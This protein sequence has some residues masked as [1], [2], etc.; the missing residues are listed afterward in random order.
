MLSKYSE[1]VLLASKMMKQIFVVQD[2]ETCLKRP[3][4]LEGIRY[5]DQ[6][7]KRGHLYLT[8]KQLRQKVIKAYPEAER[9]APELRQVL[10]PNGQIGDY[11]DPNSHYRKPKK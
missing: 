10:W 5:D 1:L 11:K 7:S 8:I 4:V 6:S 9:S 2:L 3:F